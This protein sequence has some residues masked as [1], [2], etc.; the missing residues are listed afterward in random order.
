MYKRAEQAR[1]LSFDDFDQPVGLKLDPE[2]RWVKKAEIIPWDEIEDRYAKLF[3]SGTGNP[4]KPLRMALG[5][6][7]IQKQYG[8][9]DRELV[10]QLAE[11]PYYQYFIGLPGYNPKPPFV[12]SLLVEFRKRLT[13]TILNEI[14]EMIIAHN[15]PNDHES[16]TFSGGSGNGFP[17]TEAKSENHGTLILDATC[18]P[19]YIAFP[20]DINLL[21]EARENL[22]RIIDDIC[23]RYKEDKPRMYR[24]RARKDYLALTK[25]KKR[26]AN[27]I[28]KAIKK[29]LQYV[30]RNLGYIDKFLAEGKVL[31]DK[32]T[33]RL[34]VLRKVFKQQ[35]YMYETK[36]H[37]VPD[38]I[39][40]I[41]QPFVR[42]IVR[43]KAKAPTEFGAKL[44]IS[45]D[46]ASI[47]RIEKQSFDAYNESDVLIGAAERYKQRIGGYPKRILADK[48]YRNRKN[49]AFC[50]EH[51]IRLSGPA[52]GRP[53]KLLGTDRKLEYT[54][55]VDRIEVE[56]SF[57]LAK[58]CY[59]LGLIRTKLATTTMSSIALSV[60]AMN[61]GRLAAFSL[62]DFFESVFKWTWLAI[63]RCLTG[64]NAI[65][66]VNLKM[67]CC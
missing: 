22:E 19:Q 45:I 33:E 24:L 61:V 25:R 48:I 5:S 44:D 37:S 54:D 50:K 60:I 29:Q 8:Y 36:T 9:S 63:V 11:N 64:Q 57:S 40:S 18:A 34:S 23:C 35:R 47:V 56:R 51:G 2:N 43:G 32:Q 12:P 55:A 41:S 66:S 46:D 52:L 30:R 14:N 58:R 17:P 65:K 31:S 13:D 21:N 53:K 20:Q 7:L 39:V 27:L 42:P 15:H 16:G 1:Q 49:L 3:P 62:C 6:L 67:D 38:R 10:E 28:R 4:A 26:T 59:G